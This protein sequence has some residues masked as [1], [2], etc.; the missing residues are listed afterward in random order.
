[1]SRYDYHRRSLG[2]G[3]YGAQAKKNGSSLKRTLFLLLVFIF[4]I[5]LFI[6]VFPEVDV[7]LVP[8]TQ[9]VENNFDLTLSSRVK[10]ADL[11]NGLAPARK[12]EVSDSL[13][14]EFPATGEK[15]V[16]EKASGEAV[17]YNQTGLNQPL[18]PQNDL[19][20]ESGQVFHVKTN[21]VI[22]KA[23][24]SPEGDI[25]YGNITVPIVAAE[26]GSKGNVGPVRL[27]IID[28]PFIKQSKI[29]G[30]VK[31]KLSGGTDKTVKVVSA[32]DLENA[33]RK[34]EEELKPKLRQSLKEK[35]N[36]GEVLDE[37]LARY[38]DLKT[39]KIV[40]LGEETETFK[41][42]LSL[43]LEALVWNKEEIKRL[44]QEK[45]AAG[46]EGGKRIVP[47][48]GDVF[49]AKVA[50]VDWDK[51]QAK[52]KIHSVNQVT[53][54]VDLEALKQKIKG[55]KEYEARRLLLAEPS[56]RDVR[57]KFHYSLTS[58]IPKNSNRIN[59]K[60]AVD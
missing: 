32:D 54:P 58:R 10:K 23:E 56:I 24:V 11:E 42:K 52:L 16:G 40:E 7:I 53:L 17:F 21:I 34:L 25:V 51:G 48:S 37:K 33:Q 43:K 41:M 38:T 13:E 8:A 31:D 57:F 49:E 47:S 35:L 15:N 1:M 2:D 12:V 14:K 29:Y 26:A 45:I 46:L 55:L 50:E 22:P 3:P 18:T 4:V 59:I 36:Q 19:V 39:D 5:S 9:K 44:V 20:T 28:L 27:T 60:L 30:Q 6:Y